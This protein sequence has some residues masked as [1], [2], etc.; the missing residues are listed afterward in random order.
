M[1]KRKKSGKWLTEANASLGVARNLRGVESM[2]K[3]HWL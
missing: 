3:P 2:R 1:I